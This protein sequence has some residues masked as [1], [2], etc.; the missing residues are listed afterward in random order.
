MEVYELGFII[1]WTDSTILFLMSPLACN[2]Q[3]LKKSCQNNRKLMFSGMSH[4]DDDDDDDD[5]E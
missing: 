5:D 2:K 4:F 3:I 1:G